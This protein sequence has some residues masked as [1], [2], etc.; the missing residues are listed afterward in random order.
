[1]NTNRTTNELHEAINELLA[2]YC[3]S[4]HLDGD[5]VDEVLKSC[6]AKFEEYRGIVNED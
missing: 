3:V 2:D 4:G 1:M 5:E 6:I